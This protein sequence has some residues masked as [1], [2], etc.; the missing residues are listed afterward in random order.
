MHFLRLCS[1]RYFGAQF[2][3][4]S[5]ERDKIIQLMIRIQDSPLPTQA[6]THSVWRK[7]RSVGRGVDLYHL[8]PAGVAP[9]EAEAAG[10]SHGP[11]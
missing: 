2:L 8:V 9:G 10:A 1:F 3:S 11:P 5:C 4:L 6:H 7:Q